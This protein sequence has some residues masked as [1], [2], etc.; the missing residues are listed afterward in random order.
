MT[1]AIL[2]LTL[3]MNQAPAARETPLD[4]RYLR[5]H[6]QTRGFML[7]RP[8]RPK[9]TPDGQAVL[10]LR[11]G[12]RTAKLS[13]FEFDTAT[14]K[15]RELL[16]PEQVLKGAEEMLTP[17]EKARRERQRISVGGFTD[18]QLND[19]GSQILL[20]LSG[21]LYVVGR[22]KGD[23]RELKTAPGTIVDPKFSPDGTMVGY[24]KDYDVFVYN[25]A[26]DKESAVTRGGTEEKTHG[27]AEFVAQEEMG[28]SSGWW[29]A[30][31][32]KSIV[33]E[34]AD[35]KGVEVWYVA[36]PAKP[37]AAPV[38]AYYPR[39]GKANVKVRVGVI[40][41]T[42]GET[43]W[44][45]WDRKRYEYLAQVRWQTHGPLTVTVQDRQQQE[46]ALL[47]V[48]PKTG[49]ST[50]LVTEFDSRWV[51][52]HQDGP[53]WLADG[54]FVRTGDGQ[55]G[56][57][58]EHRDAAGKQLRVLAA[59]EPSEAAPPPYRLGYQ[60]LVAVSPKTGRIVYRASADPTQSL[61]YALPGP[62]AEKGVALAEAPGMYMGSFSK[63]H[64][65]AVVTR[66][67]L[68]A[69]PRTVVYRDGKEIGELPSVAES[70][71][72][73]PRVTLDKVGDGPVYHTAIIR[74]HGFDPK[75]KYPV[76]VYV[77]GGPHHQV[78][79]QAMRGW[80][81]P[82]W[83]A[84]QGFIVVSID[85][86]GT[87]GRGRLWERALYKKFGSLPLE[88]QVAGL[89][90]LGKKHPEMDLER[91]GL[92][93]WS[94]GGYMA[95]LG[96]LRQP[97]VFKVGVAGAPVTEWLDYDTHY[98]ERY[99]GLPEE[100]P[101]AYKEG[102]LLTYAADLKRPL[103]LIHGTADDNVYFRHSLRLADALFRAGKDFDILPLPGLTHMVPDPVVMERLYG[104]IAAKFSQHLGKPE[105][106]R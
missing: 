12:P 44:V 37:D 89:K 34:E 43:V 69:M 5:D 32:S 55:D 17:E 83:I 75:K 20:T 88:D 77:Y 46:I 1:S 90:A 54:S 66:T 38:N 80:L 45:D 104:K 85:N 10:F 6:A 67:G 50:V 53:H 33:Y 82:Q 15:T 29:W 2:L 39:P 26:A 28:R 3:A 7:G 87:P 60:E 57:R 40:P 22:A 99:L 24:V 102:S 51:N 19:D 70:P 105:P 49:K 62:V 101:E 91:V 73:T 74:P 56:L 27:L 47:K 71:G 103:L 61:L 42:G 18:F 65:V 96:V 9:V 31:D 63:D 58:L 81:L 95:G 59:A 30:P 11:S 14:A 23:V 21:R 36:D 52:L 4:A 100:N 16:T 25:L 86:R 48:D 76:V 41:V 64:A 97:E 8:S 78:V 13:L 93:G 106:P 72:F 94:F 79:E 84:D 35:A 68:D 92:Y 98:T